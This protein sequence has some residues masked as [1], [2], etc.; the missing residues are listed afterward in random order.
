MEKHKLTWVQNGELFFSPYLN[1]SPKII[2]YTVF[3]TLSTALTDEWNIIQ[4]VYIYNFFQ[5]E[6]FHIILFL[7]IKDIILIQLVQVINTFIIIRAHN[8][9]FP[10][11]L[12]ALPALTY[13]DF[14]TSLAQVSIMLVAQG[15]SLHGERYQNFACC[16]Y[17]QYP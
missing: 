12:Y 5:F 4:R 9:S 6:S 3:V 15:S 13:V 1:L 16:K 10:V 17:K 8:L 7:R 11:L 14:S 2:Y